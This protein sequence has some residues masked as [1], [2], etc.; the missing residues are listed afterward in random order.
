MPQVDCTDILR[1]LADRTRLRI[2]KALLAQPSGVNDLSAVLRLSQ[3][4]TSKHLRILRQAGVVQVEPVGA[5]GNTRSRRPCESGSRAKVRCSTSD[6]AAFALT[7]YR[8]E[9]LA[10]V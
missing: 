1:A 3:Y 2:V 8:T 7:S 5:G 9:L 6:A 10:T 4:N